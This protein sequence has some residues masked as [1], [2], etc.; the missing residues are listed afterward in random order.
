MS[1]SGPA[2]GGGGGRVSGSG[3]VGGRVSGSG[4]A[5]GR[6]SSSGPAGHCLFENGGAEGERRGIEGEWLCSSEVEGERCWW[7]NPVSRERIGDIYTN[8]DIFIFHCR[9]CT[10]FIDIRVHAHAYEL[11]LLF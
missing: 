3:P 10:S 1:G 8:N 2:G 4:P 5:G 7:D 6:E 11:S 9:T